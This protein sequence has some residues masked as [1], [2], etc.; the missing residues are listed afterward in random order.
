MTKNGLIDFVQS[1]A[2]YMKKG[3]SFAYL[4]QYDA[5][6]RAFFTS[7]VVRKINLFRIAK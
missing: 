3:G 5:F 1:W 4:G 2:I 7:A 6:K